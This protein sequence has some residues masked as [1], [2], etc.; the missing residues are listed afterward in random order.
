MQLLSL[1]HSEATVG[2]YGLILILSY[3][4]ESG[5]LRTGREMGGRPVG[6]VGAHTT[7]TH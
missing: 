2:L 5:G 6:A 1:E 3:L 4:E 7:L